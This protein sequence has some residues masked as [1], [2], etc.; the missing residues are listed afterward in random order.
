MI[1]LLDYTVVKYEDDAKVQEME[2]GFD[3]LCEW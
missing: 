3:K 1:L 2:G